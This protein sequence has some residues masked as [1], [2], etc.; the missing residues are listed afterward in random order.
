L[1][2]IAEYPDVSSLLSNP[3][4]EIVIDDGRRWLSK[5]RDRRF[6]FIAMNSSFSW[7]AMATNLLSVEFLD[8]VKAHL[9]DNGVFLYNTTG[10]PEAERTGAAYFPFA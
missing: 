3:K 1:N 5:N 4:V 6:D 8:L 9:K 10:S 2:I 7:R